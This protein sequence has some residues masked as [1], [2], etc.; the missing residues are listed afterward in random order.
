MFYSYRPILQNRSD[1]YYLFISIC[2]IT[3]ASSLC[4]Y[5][6]HILGK[7]SPPQ[8]TITVPIIKNILVS[9]QA[10]YSVF[11][12]RSVFYLFYDITIIFKVFRDLDMSTLGFRTCGFAV[13]S[14]LASI[15]SPWLFFMCIN[16][17]LPIVYIISPCCS[18]FFMV[19]IHVSRFGRKITPLTGHIAPDVVAFNQPAY[20]AISL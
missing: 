10:L 16:F 7:S 6:L 8:N 9:G 1:C 12:H 5:F 14:I 11:W 17:Y 15:F 20:G 19:E 13:T 3:V 18:A 4:K 2:Y